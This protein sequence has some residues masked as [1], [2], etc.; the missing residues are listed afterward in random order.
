MSIEKAKR[1]VSLERQYGVDREYM[2]AYFYY[3]DGLLFRRKRSAKRQKLHHGNWA[4]CKDGYM[5]IRL[6]GHAFSVHRLIWVLHNSLIPE[7][8]Q[9]DHINRIR[10]D[11]R[12]ENLRVV[13]QRQNLSNHGISTASGYPGVWWYE[14]CKTWQVRIQVDRKT[15]NLGYHKDLDAAIA[16]RKDAELNYE[17]AR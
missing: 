14:R 17:E 11:N 5:R 7:G 4:V 3:K 6:F 12:I 2:A 1:S 15:I 8:M 13:T 9:I 16:V 10:T